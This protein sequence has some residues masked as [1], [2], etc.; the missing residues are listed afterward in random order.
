MVDT[1]ERVIADKGYFDDACITSDTIANPIEYSLH[2]MLR[3]RHETTNKRFKQFKVLSTKFRRDLSFHASCFHAVACMKQQ[4]FK[5]E[6]LF[7]VEF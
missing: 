6:P 7:E 5:Y 4:I 2:S 3:A 1:G